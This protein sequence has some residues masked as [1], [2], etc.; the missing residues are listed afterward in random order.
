MFVRLEDFPATS[1]ALSE[2]ATLTAT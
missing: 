2:R 1:R